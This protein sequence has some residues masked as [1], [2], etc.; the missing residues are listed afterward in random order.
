MPGEKKM[1]SPLNIGLMLIRGSWNFS[2][3]EDKQHSIKLVLKVQDTFL[4]VFWQLCDKIFLV[5]PNLEH[6]QE[7]KY[8]G[9]RTS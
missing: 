3:Q 2:W 1:S 9:K 7:E 5:N 4:R 6:P 8:I